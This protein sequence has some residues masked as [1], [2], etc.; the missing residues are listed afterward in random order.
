M[1]QI[2]TG[3]GLISGLNI[4]DIIDQLVAVESRPK[5]TIERRNA[6]LQTQQTAY[7]EVNAKMLALGLSAEGL[8]RP[9][10][11]RQTH[12]TSSDEEVLSVTS[13]TGATPGNYLM[14]V[15]QL[16][17][18]QQS[19]TRGFEDADGQPLAPE[20]GAV[21]RFERGET[22]LA[23]KTTLDVLNGGE[24]V[25]RGS[26]RL[27][28]R[29]GASAVVDLADAVTLDDVADTINRTTGV[30]VSAEVT[31]QG[32]RL[33]DGTGR[34]SANFAVAEVGRGRTAATLGL[35]GSTSSDTLTSAN[36]NTLGR[37]TYLNTLNDSLGVGRARG[38]DDL[39]ITD[40]AGT[41]YGVN[42]DDAATL[43]D[44]FDAIE[45]ATAGAVLAGVSGDGRRIVLNETTGGGGS[46][47]VVAANGSA[48]VDDLGL[49]D[50]EPAPPAPDPPPPAT[51]QWSFNG[52]AGDGRGGLIG[53][54]QGGAAYVPDGVRGQAVS[55]D[56]TSGYVEIDN[57]AI[58]DSFEQYSVSMWINPADLDGNQ[59]LYEEGGT[60]HGIGMRL[61]GSN[62][63][64]A[65]RF[66]GVQ[67]SV[68]VAGVQAD[69]W[70][71]ATMTFDRG[72]L[73]VR[74]DDTAEA[75]LTT[76]FPNIAAH[77]SAAAVGRANGASV[78][79]SG[80]DE[81]FAGLVDELR[82][83][84]GQ[85][86][87]ASETQAIYAD[88]NPYAQPVGD[89]LTG[90]AVLADVNSRLLR[91]LHG[92]RGLT[93]FGGE[94][95]LPVTRDTALTDLLGG[96]GLPTTGD[97]SPDLTIRS[98]NAVEDSTAT[99]IDLDAL[100]TVGDLLDAIATATSGATVASLDGNRL[101]LA[102]TTDG[103]EHLVIADAPG[104]TVASALGLNVD[105]AVGVVRSGELD[106]AGTLEAGSTLRITHS[107]GGSG[108]VTISGAE[109]VT[110]VLRA[111]NN[112]GLGVR[113][114]IN[115]AG[116]GIRLVDTARGRGDLVVEDVEG[117]LGAQLGL[118]GTY[119][120]AVAEGADL[121]LRYVTG[122]TSLDALGVARGKFTLRDSSG[123]TAT[124]D[125]TQGDENTIGD[126]LSEINSRGLLLNARVNET[127]D[128]IVIEDLG[129]GTVEVRA[130]DEGSTTAADLGLAGAAVSAGADLEGT[131]ERIV[132]VGTSATL[133]DV[134]NRINDGRVG[135]SA[136]VVNDGSPSAPF[137]L[138]LSSRTAGT[139]GAFSFDDGGLG[140]QSEVLSDAQD[141]VVFYGST[142][143]ARALTITSQTNQLKGVLP[144]TTIDLHS[145]SDRPVQVTVSEN[146]EAVST[147]VQKFVDDFNGMIEAINKHDSYDAESQQRGLLLGDSAV[148]QVRSAV[149][150]AVIGANA[151]LTGRF[152]SLSEVGITVGSG[153]TLQLDTAKLNAAL[154]EDVD[155]VLDLFT[156]R[157]TQT[158][159]DGEEIVT[160]RGIGVEIDEVLD[161]LTDTESG[162]LSRQVANI[163]KQIELNR[164][165]VESL[166]ILLG[167]KR[168]RLEAQFQAMEQALASLQDQ[169]SSIAQL[170]ALA[171][172]PAR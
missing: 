90:K 99:G 151:E 118:A 150:N 21:L 59:H 121:N 161:R 56:G 142:D 50:F 167:Q 33:S 128:G 148:S 20:R 15:K 26:I 52:S 104:S 85:A 120:D 171:Q 45:D 122:S 12:A 166:D 6:L 3:V 137:R 114:E 32:L 162:P 159:P 72:Q 130:L 43:G 103:D 68:S 31:S 61:T 86:L 134:A 93:A 117:V 30:N 154:E 69:R 24:G 18:S 51:N 76:P 119:E 13:G 11:F 94:G 116:S 133:Q 2:T 38:R 73:S 113:A 53:S 4:A 146:R 36:L 108:E 25:S 22:R 131:F 109:S 29:S 37:E 125:L 106:P 70:Q 16:V 35:L 14:R 158:G 105:A 83:Y 149:Y 147:A 92:G 172:P 143:P 156:F 28:D 126:V 98:R 87:T 71:L 144:G 88:E 82:V 1:G 170:S 49:T 124:V 17:G 75:T 84:D 136:A 5:A 135:I 60:T 41:E 157:E 169:S 163:D 96:A 97:A 58:E 111:I 77:T 40:T 64:A 65:V 155:A 95:V 79:S 47:G 123:A 46:F 115:A 145:V 19:V 107:A 55:L 44:V 153:A 160:A 48:A 129:P 168:S 10:L 62:L 27:T 34:T 66:N 78:F 7:Q 39:I 67:Q 141:A 102:D 101:L 42:L 138:S 81:H 110:D 9:T 100:T 140:M 63:E 165:R 8:I 57:D 23:T 132:A 80:D 139:G 89:T 112:A 127:G 152:D 91:N 74:L 164:S 54:L